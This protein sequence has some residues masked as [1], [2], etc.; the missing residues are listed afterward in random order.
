MRRAPK[1]V[2]S[3]DGKFSEAVTGAVNV[4]DTTELVTWDEVDMKL[5]AI[6]E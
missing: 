3:G 2:D 6:E 5:D 4:G 1:E